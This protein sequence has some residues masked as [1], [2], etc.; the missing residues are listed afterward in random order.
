MEEQI[1]EYS[2]VI[3]VRHL[4]LGVKC[5]E[6]QKEKPRCCSRVLC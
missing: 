4:Y 2:A 3:H 6:E 1:E 5:D